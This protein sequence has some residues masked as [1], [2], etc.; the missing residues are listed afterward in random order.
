VAETASPVRAR[1]TL[2][3]GLEDLATI[4]PWFE[5]IAEKIGLPANSL[6]RIQL[7]LE[8]A[9]SNAALHGFDSGGVGEISL[10]VAANPT[11]V[12]AVLSDQGRPFDP[13]TEAPPS[14]A[15]QS[16]EEAAIGGLGIKLMHKFATAL[17]YRRTGTTNELTMT[18]DVASARDVMNPGD[19][20][21][22]GDVMSPGKVTGAAGR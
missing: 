8:E 19:V 15:P 17:H 11:Q 3:S 16:L 6:F 14:P 22:S 2:R 5:S 18:F 7:V 4:Y 9:A 20:M 13:L 1:L 10:E 12:I 21:S